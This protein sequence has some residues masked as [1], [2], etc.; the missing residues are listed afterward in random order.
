VLIGDKTITAGG[1]AFTSNGVT[2]SALPSGGIF[3][4]SDGKTSTDYPGINGQIS[5]GGGQVASELHDSADAASTFVVDGHTILA[6]GSAFITDGVTYTAMPSGSGIEVISAGK[7]TEFA[8]AGREEIVTLANGQRVTIDPIL[9][10]VVSITTIDGQAMTLIPDGVVIDGTTVTEC[11][12]AKTI[13]HT[14]YSVNAHGQ[15]VIAGAKTLG[16]NGGYGLLM[17]AIETAAE[18]IGEGA[19]TTSSSASAGLRATTTAAVTSGDGPQVGPQSAPSSISTSGAGLVRDRW[20]MA[21]G[22]SGAIV[23]GLFAC[24][25]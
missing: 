21:V 1:A 7:T 16:S 13:H 14:V 18:R 5:L 3:E 24:M 17:G 9:P 8:P 2:Y 11:G 12:A 10:G 22:A 25:L 19:A 6:G 23:L 4:I 20:S 15:L